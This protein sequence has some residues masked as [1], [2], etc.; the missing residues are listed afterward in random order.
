VIRINIVKKI[1][2]FFIL[3]TMGLKDLQVFFKISF[4]PIE[5]LSISSLKKLDEL[6]LEEFHKQIN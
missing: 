2:M 3:G 1:T 5:I 4:E 6:R